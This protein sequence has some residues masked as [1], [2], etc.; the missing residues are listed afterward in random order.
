MWSSVDFACYDAAVLNVVYANAPQ[1]YEERHAA[2]RAAVAGRPESEVL[3]H[4][5]SAM[6]LAKRI[7]KS[8]KSAAPTDLARAI[9]EG[10]AS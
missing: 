6:D 2:I 7:T 9:R 1:L 5:A 10:A 3:E 4:V 8:A